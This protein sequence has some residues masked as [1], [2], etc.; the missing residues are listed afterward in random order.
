[1]KYKIYINVK[2]QRDIFANIFDLDIF[3]VG[4]GFEYYTLHFQHVFIF[5]YL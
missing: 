3:S 5:T 1:M 2:F 4:L